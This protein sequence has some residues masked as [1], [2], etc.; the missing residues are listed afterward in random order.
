MILQAKLNI[1]FF[2]LTSLF[3]AC[4]FIVCHI[5]LSL[6]QKYKNCNLSYINKYK[7]VMGLFKTHHLNSV[8]FLFL[9]AAEI[10]A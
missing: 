9:P 2:I 5:E 6:L 1:N 3:S 8:Y 4:L 10:K 7:K